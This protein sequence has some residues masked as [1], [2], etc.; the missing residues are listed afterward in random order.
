M[1]NKK[2]GSLQDILGK[3]DRFVSNNDIDD[4][5]EVTIRAFNVKS[6]KGTRI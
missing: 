2:I 1:G 5:V 3:W 6:G 4:E